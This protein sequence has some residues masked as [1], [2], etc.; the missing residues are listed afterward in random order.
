[1]KTNFQTKILTLCF[2]VLATVSFA[3]NLSRTE[4]KILKSIEA[5]NTEAIEFLK[6][7]ININ[8]GT[9]IMKA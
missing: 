7:V 8:S 2:L 3:Q 6:K 4:K 9:M 5:N 1:M